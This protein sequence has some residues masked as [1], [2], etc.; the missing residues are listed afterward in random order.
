MSDIV[1][2]DTTVLL[3]VLDVP[4]RNEQRQD[5]LAQLGALIDSNAHLFIPM[6]AIV[7]AGNH[8]AHVPNGHHRREAAGRF[9]DAI[10][11]ALNDEAPW[12]PVNFPSREA[13][14][15]WLSGFL[16]SATQGIGIGDMSIIMEWES[17]CPK[18]AMSRVLIWSLDEHLQGY[19]RPTVSGHG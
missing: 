14:L 18:Y 16:E 5:V 15:E 1:L 6:A 19:E 12:K 3:N 4:G 10:R 8:I 13:M 17:C 2:V 11:A 9:V 7:E